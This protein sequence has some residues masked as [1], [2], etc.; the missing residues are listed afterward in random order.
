MS[1]IRIYLAGPITDQSYAGATGWRK[2]LSQQFELYFPGHFQFLSPMRDKIELSNEVCMNKGYSDVSILCTPQSIVTRDLS[3]VRR[4]D[5]IILGYPE[6]DMPVSF[7]TGAEL[8]IAYENR[9]PV[10]AYFNPGHALCS[11]PFVTGMGVPI[12]HT[13]YDL[14]VLVS[15][16]FNL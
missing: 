14:T 5:L 6:A 13:T 11:H 12:V 10:V 4:S 8:G 3:D 1:K 16:I 7:G 2:E 15:S 9:K